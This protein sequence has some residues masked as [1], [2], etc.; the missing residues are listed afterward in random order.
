CTAGGKDWRPSSPPPSPDRRK[1]MKP[2]RCK[3]Y[4]ARL[5]EWLDQPSA[6]ALPADLA[7]HVRSCTMCRKL[8]KQWN[9]IEVQMLAARTEVPD[10]SRGFRASLQARLQGP[11]VSQPV[12]SSIRMS[13]PVID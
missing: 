12:W 4:R 8:I 11:P 5:H 10:L 6:P 2:M 1:R 7:E 3:S 13:W 9:A